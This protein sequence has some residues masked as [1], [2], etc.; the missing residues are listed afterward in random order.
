M[1]PKR[2]WSDKLWAI[3]LCFFQFGSSYGLAQFGFCQ[4]ELDSQLA[5][6]GFFQ[7]KPDFR[8]AQWASGQPCSVLITTQIQPEYSGVGLENLD[9]GLSSD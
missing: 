3:R 6:L 5:Q 9:S 4:F 7:F 1:G 8:L 2:L